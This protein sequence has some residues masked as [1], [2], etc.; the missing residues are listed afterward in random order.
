MPKMLEE[1]TLQ[2]NPGKA[3]K[4]VTGVLEQILTRTT[5]LELLCENPGARQQLVSLCCASP[6]LPSSWRNSPCCWMN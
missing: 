3:F 6:G 5:Y 2:P 4:P 1:L